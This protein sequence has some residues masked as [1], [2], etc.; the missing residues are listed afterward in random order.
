[1]NKIGKK[2]TKLKPIR[3]LNY[4]NWCFECVGFLLFFFIIEF[5]RSTLFCWLGRWKRCE[6]LTS[7]IWW[8]FGTSLN[9][10]RRLRKHSNTLAWSVTFQCRLETLMCVQKK[11]MVKM[12]FVC[13]S[14]KNKWNFLCRSQWILRICTVTIQWWIC[15]MEILHGL[16]QMLIFLR[17]GFMPNI[18]VCYMCIV[19]S[20]ENIQFERISL[21]NSSPHNS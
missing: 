6:I 20:E 7:M 17:I 9:I 21:Q 4:M 15:Y 8:D 19:L 5:N 14:E 18:F 2:K 16:Y 3:W 12:L 13:L 10:M 11:K 1:M